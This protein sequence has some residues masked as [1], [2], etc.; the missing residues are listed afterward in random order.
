MK[1][2]AALAL[3]LALTGCIHKPS[4]TNP[5]I[6]IPGAANV[7]DQDAFRALD[8]AHA[9][10][11]TA[12]ANAP[13]LTAPEKQALNTFILA[14]NSADTLYAA[15]HG[16]AATQAQMQTALDKVTASQSQYA[17]AVTGGK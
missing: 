5:A 8:S 9:F 11:T 14:L 6:L 12:A 1:T 13:S 16:G 10:A 3:C 4:S 7:F 15:Y 17:T 2:F